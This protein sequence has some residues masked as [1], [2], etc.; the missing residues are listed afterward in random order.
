M[1]FMNS[2]RLLVG[3]LAVFL[4]NACSDASG[5]AN[6]VNASSDPLYAFNDF[7]DSLFHGIYWNQPIAESRNQLTKQGFELVDSSGALNYYNQ[8]DSTQVIIPDES[9]IRNLKLVLRS[10]NYLASGPR[11]MNGFS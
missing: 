6:S 7:P 2:I 8:A 3:L 5:H 9:K 1:T 11:L 4:T 10:H